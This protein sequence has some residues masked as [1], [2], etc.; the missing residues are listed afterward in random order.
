MCFFI[1]RDNFVP[2][3]PCLTKPSP[4]FLMEIKWDQWMP[5]VKHLAINAIAFKAKVANS[6][7]AW[8]LAFHSHC[9]VF[10]SSANGLELSNKSLLWFLF[11]IYFSTIWSWIFISL[12]PVS[13]LLP[14]FPE[15]HSQREK[16]GHLLLFCFTC[17]V[18]SNHQSIG[19]VL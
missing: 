8:F 16:H 18:R 4:S 9:Y 12:F 5:M 14:S 13:F 15:I 19:L 7:W 6:C 2:I 10:L 3:P 17:V 1:P 11:Q